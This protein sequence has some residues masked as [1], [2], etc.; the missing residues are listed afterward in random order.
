MKVGDTEVENFIIVGDNLFLLGYR[1]T[2]YGD[3]LSFRFLDWK[4]IICRLKRE[5]IKSDGGNFKSD[6]STCLSHSLDALARAAAVAEFRPRY[7]CTINN[8]SIDR[9]T[10]LR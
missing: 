4:F 8:L 2:H 10:S 6:T 1:H 5:H 3:Y 9:S 7:F